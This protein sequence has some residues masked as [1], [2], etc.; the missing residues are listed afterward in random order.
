M[1]RRNFFVVYRQCAFTEDFS[2]NIKRRDL[3][4]IQVGRS[5]FAFAEVPSGSLYKAHDPFESFA[6]CCA[7]R[8]P[9]PRQSGGSSG[10]Q[11]R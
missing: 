2:S 9:V 6:T 10:D 5:A 4:R 7:R 8:F 11:R 1:I 3:S